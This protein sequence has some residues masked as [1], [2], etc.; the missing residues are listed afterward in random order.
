MVWNCEI[1]QLRGRARPSCQKTGGGG[2]SEITADDGR[3]AGSLKDKARSVRVLNVMSKEGAEAV[4]IKPEQKRRSYFRVD[5][6]ESNMTP[7]AERAEWRKFVSVPLDNGTMELP[8]DWIGV[9]TAWEMPDGL[10]G[11]TTSDLSRVQKLVNEGDWRESSKSPDW[12]GNA[13]AQALNPN[14]GEK[15]VRARVSKMLPRGQKITCSNRCAANQRPV[16]IG[17][18]SLR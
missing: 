14:I 12:V 9:V 4:G 8:G 6:G 18:Y 17:T 3:G 13:V 7:P 10:D 2:T 16:R 5:D 11:L 15:H 1:M